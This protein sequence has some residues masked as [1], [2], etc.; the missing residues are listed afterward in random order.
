M[1]A[2]PACRLVFDAWRPCCAGLFWVGCTAFSGLTGAYVLRGLRWC[3]LI[4]MHARFAILRGIYAYENR[5]Q[6]GCKNTT[7][8]KECHSFI[9]IRADK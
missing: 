8:N 9:Y 3:N 1:I 4:F 2:V 7:N 6:P 5:R